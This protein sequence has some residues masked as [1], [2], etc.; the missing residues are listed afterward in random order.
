MGM[1]C[2]AVALWL[3]LSIGV[4]LLFGQVCGFGDDGE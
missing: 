2:G 1:I 4:G 3:L